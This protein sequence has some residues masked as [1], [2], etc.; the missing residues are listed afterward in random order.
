LTE[1]GIL[2]ALRVRHSGVCH[3][4][5]NR[6]NCQFLKTRLDA[7]TEAQKEDVSGE[8]Q[9]YGNPTIGL[10]YGISQIWTPH[11]SVTAQQILMKLETYNYCQKT[12]QHA[13]R[14]FNQTM[15]VIWVNCQFATVRLLSL[16][17]LVSRAWQTD[18]DNLYVI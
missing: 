14:Y 4:G 5:K 3:S 18:F 11:S 10:S 2:A 8:T 15:W 12:T 13:K 9:M 7:L 1:I 6:T 16:S 17:F